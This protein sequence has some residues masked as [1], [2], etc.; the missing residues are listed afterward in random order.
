MT[1]TVAPS[2]QLLAGWGQI[3]RTLAKIAAQCA[4]VERAVAASPYVKKQ[5]AHKAKTAAM[6][7]ALI[8]ARRSL[9]Q[10]TAETCTL[11]APRAL[12]ACTPELVLRLHQGNA[13]NARQHSPRPWEASPI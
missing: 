3:E 1:A 9:R 8:A 2:V 6:L 7:A 11:S 5:Q 10:V 12:V 13:P 4:V